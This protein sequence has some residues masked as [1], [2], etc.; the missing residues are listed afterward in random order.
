MNDATRTETLRHA[1]Q[2]TTM[3][4]GP[5]ADRYQSALERYLAA[6]SRPDSPAASVGY[7]VVGRHMTDV[8]VRDVMTTDVVSV[9]E[10][11]PFSAIVAALAT[12][13]LGAVPVVD[14]DG[15]IA[16]IVSESDL[17]SRV[18]ADPA[19]GGTIHGGFAGSRATRV[20]ARAETARTL[21]STP[22]VTIH[23]RDSI[24]DAARTAARAHVRR[25]PVVTDDGSLVGMVT[26]SDLLGVFLR[27]DPEIHEHVVEVIK[28]SCAVDPSTVEVSVQDGVVSLHGQLERR[29]QLRPF[30]DAIRAVAGVVSV[31]DDHLTYRHDDIMSPAPR[32]PLY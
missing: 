28:Q 3:H 30:L 20:K 7:R 1:V 22:P 5:T 14:D 24:V 18:L 21:M 6:V 31:H 16:G 4:G 12:S 13:R 26:R 25:L 29:G 15:R 19:S 23:A 10:D 2:S 32:A 11:A 9:G 8:S 17:I 27:S